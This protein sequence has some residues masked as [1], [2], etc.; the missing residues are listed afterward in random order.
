ML[1]YSLAITILLLALPLAGNAQ[2]VP[3]FSFAMCRMHFKA[4]LGVVT[5]AQRL[6]L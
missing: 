2:V 4:M 5:L 6:R 3:S 1:R